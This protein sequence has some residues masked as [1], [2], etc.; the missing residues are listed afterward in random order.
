MNTLKTIRDSDF[1]LNHPIGTSYKER[2]A[3]R[4][5]VFDKDKNV[6]LLYSTKKD[7]YKLPGGG[8]EKKETIASALKR[9]LLEEIGCSVENIRELGI[10]E[11]YRNKFELHQLSYCFLADILGDK[12]TPHF[13]EDEIAE[14]F[15][16]V[17]MSIEEA[18]KTL[19]SEINVEDYEGK[20][21]HLRDLTFLKEA[22]RNI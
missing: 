17:W 11:E 18:I 8:V 5:I 22:I 4:A 15:E 9:E 10:I 6:A 7:Y 1:G 13:E 16:P 2:K 19:E 3:S 21:I 20:F 12:S 14:G